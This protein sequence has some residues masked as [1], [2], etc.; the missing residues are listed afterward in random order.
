MSARREGGRAGEGE[1][2]HRLRAWLVE[3]LSDG[4]VLGTFQKW[5]VLC[6]VR[7]ALC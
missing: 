3:M 5:P 2:N 1:E 6:K 4:T 7:F